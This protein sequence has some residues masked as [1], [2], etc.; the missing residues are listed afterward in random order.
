MKRQKNTLVIIL[1]IYAILMLWLTLL[2]LSRYQYQGGIRAYEMK[3]YDQATSHLFAAKKILPQKIADILGKRDLFRIHT[4]LGKTLYQ[5]ALILIK[6]TAVGTT[7]REN[8]KSAYA[9][10]KQGHEFLKTAVAHDPLSYRT[11]FWYAKITAKVAALQP[12]FDSHLPPNTY[13]P[14]P[15]FQK[16]AALRPAGITVR[17]EMAHYYH[18]KQMTEKLKEMVEEIAT[19]YP[20]SH[21]YLKTQSWF[22]ADVKIYFRKGCLKAL[23]AGTT[24][25]ETLSILSSISLGDGQ[26]DAA[27]NYYQRSMGYKPHLNSA[28]THRY[29]AGLYFKKG[30]MDQSFAL[31]LKALDRS[32]DLKGEL[33]SIYRRFRSEKKF[34]EFLQFI[35]YVEAHRPHSSVEKMILVRCFMDMGQLEMAKARLE[36]MNAQQPT[37]HAWYLLANIAEKQ[38]DWDAMELASQRATVLENSNSQYHYYFCRALQRKKKHERAEIAVTRALETAKKKTAGLY[39]HRAWIRWTLKNYPGAIEDWRQCLE[40]H[41]DNSIYYFNIARSFHQ[42]SMDIKAMNYARRAHE[43]APDNKKYQDWILQL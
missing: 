8:L 13:D 18:G 23:A 11:M 41:P 9:L 38:K 28:V 1:S 26:V 4:A 7:R 6:Q 35:R 37:A 12:Y 2:L 27:I 15:V 30:D 31:F 10:F 16:A 25:R 17:Y 20:M 32:K 5:Q 34:D 24:P 42:Q 14:L 39:N 33:N 19:I 3:E 40:L 43:L 29:L 36:R 21:G 22:D